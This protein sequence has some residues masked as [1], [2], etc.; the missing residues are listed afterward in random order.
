MKIDVFNKIIH[1]DKNFADSIENC[2]HSSYTNRN[3]YDC[4]YSNVAKYFMHFIVNCHTNLFCLK[5]EIVKNSQ[6]ILTP[7]NLSNLYDELKRQEKKFKKKQIIPRNLKNPKIELQNCNVG[8]FVI[9]Q[10]YYEQ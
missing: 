6:K 4:D 8:K 9:N 7:F 10:K 1:C 5:V 3:A 2:V